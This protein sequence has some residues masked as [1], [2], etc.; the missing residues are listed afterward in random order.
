[1]DPMVSIIIPVYNAETTLRRCVLSVLGQQYED[2]ELLLIDDGSSDGS[3]GMCDEFARKD[4]RVRVVHKKNAGVSAARNDAIRLARGRYL[5][6][7]D[8]DDWI[9]PD[10]TRP[11]A[12][13]PVLPGKTLYLRLPTDSAIQLV[14]PV[15]TRHSG[16][17]DVVLYIEAT[18][19]KLRAPAQ[20]R[21]RPTKALLGELS[22][23]LGAKNVVLK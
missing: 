3:G 19:A 16:Q 5:Q 21:V 23:M 11:A 14:R 15:L 1:M 17:T 2:F 12:Q 9:T 18:G 22:G 10:A 13:E 7:L 4:A 20:L 8:S 6:F